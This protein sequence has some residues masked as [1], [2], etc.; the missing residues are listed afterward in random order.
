M[1]YSVLAQYVVAL[2]LYGSVHKLS[3]TSSFTDTV[4]T[5]CRYCN[6]RIIKYSSSGGIL[7]IMDKPVDGLS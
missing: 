7:Q 3:C 1:A 5:H 4:C 6:H 2:V